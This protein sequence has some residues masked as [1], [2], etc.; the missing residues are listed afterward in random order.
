MSFTIYSV[1][2]KDWNIEMNESSCLL[3]QNIVINLN[4]V[5]LTRGTKQSD[6]PTKLPL[7]TDRY[8]AVQ[9][10]LKV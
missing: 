6:K 7:L 5:I 8:L 4:V 2:S 1:H 9:E 10:D 3:Y